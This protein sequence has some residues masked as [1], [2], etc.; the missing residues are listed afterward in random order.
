MELDSPDQ[1]ATKPFDG[2]VVRKDLVRKYARHYPVPTYVVEFLL[3]RYCA[4]TNDDEIRE[5]L[6]VVEQQ[7]D[8]RTVRTGREELFK[9]KARTDGNV[10]LIDIVKARLDAKNDCYL[11]E[12]PSLALRDVQVADRFVKEHE[13]M[14]TDGFYAE[15]TSLAGIDQPPL[16]TGCRPVSSAGSRGAAHDL[17]VK[18]R[19]ARPLGGEPIQAGRANG[20]RTETTEVTVALVVG[21]DDE[22]VW[23]RGTSDE[24]EAEK[25]QKERGNGESHEGNRWLRGGIDSIPQRV[26]DLEFLPH[27]RRMEELK[28]REFFPAE[29]AGLGGAHFGDEAA[30][31]VD[32]ERLLKLQSGRGEPVSGE[33]G[34]DPIP[35]DVAGEILFARTGEQVV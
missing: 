28:Q 1:L 23:L 8:N 18:A 30:G 3:G 19:E 12:L 11:A 24:G 10:R 15:V 5:G 26:D 31:M 16:R 29:S 33:S 32:E 21:E 34:A 9:S 6:T 22:E 4:S 35:A 14:L 20:R 7:L 13:R 25:R 27:L 2:F 17:G